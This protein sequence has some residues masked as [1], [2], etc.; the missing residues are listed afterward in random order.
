ML[1]T[2]EPAQLCR[3]GGGLSWQILPDPP[4]SLPANLPTGLRG[5]LL[6]AADAT[7]LASLRRTV[8]ERQLDSPDYYRL[9]AESPAFPASHLGP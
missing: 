4:P 6:T 8:I 2:T 9:E 7:A 3:S 5:R 1:S